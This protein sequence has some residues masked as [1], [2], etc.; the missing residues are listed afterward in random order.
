MGL[1]DQRMTSMRA[2]YLLHSCWLL[3]FPLDVSPTLPCE[4]LR[5]ALFT[6]ASCG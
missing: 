5:F 2:R 4:S 6:A 1:L 3:S